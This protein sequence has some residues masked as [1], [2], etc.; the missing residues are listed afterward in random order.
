M[1]LYDQMLD[2]VK[3]REHID[4]EIE[5]TLGA[6]TPLV[7][8]R[9][10]ILA[11]FAALITSMAMRDN[12]DNIALTNLGALCIGDA[13]SSKIESVA[14]YTNPTISECEISVVTV[15]EKIFISVTEC[16]IDEN[17]VSDFAGI[18]TRL[19]MSISEISKK[20]ISR[21]RLKL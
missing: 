5:K 11:D 19:G 17:I 6:I 14:L 10:R 3:S 8:L 1:E 12:R 18:C 15:G 20:T 21:S 4:G 7:N 16:Y 2:S 9:P 13:C